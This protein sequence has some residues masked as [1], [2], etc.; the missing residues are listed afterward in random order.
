MEGCGAILFMVADQPML[1]R[2]TVAALVDFFAEEPEKIAALGHGGKRGNPCIFPAAFF[3][4]LLALE[5]DRGGSA[6]IRRHGESL[7]LMECA[8]EELRD[9]DELGDLAVLEEY[10]G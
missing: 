7:R 10:A 1:R 5:G 2:D 9:V 8:E 4:E 6:V 3:P